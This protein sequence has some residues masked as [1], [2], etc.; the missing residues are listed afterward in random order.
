MM[1]DKAGGAAAL[2]LTGC[3]QLFN[4]GEEK[5]CVSIMGALCITC[6]KSQ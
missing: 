1:K 3:A 4:N 2:H 5:Q 6:R